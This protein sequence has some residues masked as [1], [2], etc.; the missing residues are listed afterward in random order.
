MKNIF[1]SIFLLSSFLL[2]AQDKFQT[3]HGPYLCNPT[4]TEMSI[5]WTT[6]RPAAFWVEIAINDGSHLYG[7]S[8]MM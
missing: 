2:H 3:T 1:F 7:D 8:L 5:V 4:E 6:N